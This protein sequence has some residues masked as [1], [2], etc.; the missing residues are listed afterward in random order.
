MKS[1]SLKTYWTLALKGL[2]IQVGPFVISLLVNTRIQS[3]HFI[4]LSGYQKSDKYKSLF[5]MEIL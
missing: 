1:V 3:S 4:F 5:K 2:R